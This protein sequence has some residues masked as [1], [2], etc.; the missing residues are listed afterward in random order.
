[1]QNNFQLKANGEIGRATNKTAV[2]NRLEILKVLSSNVLL[3]VESLREDRA[4]QTTISLAA[5]VARFE[6]DLIRGA[7]IRTGGRQHLAAQLLGV[8]NNTLNG[9]I[10]RYRIAL[11]GLASFA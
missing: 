4:A 10:R 3:E 8:K 9:K 2:I 6:A 5:E 1:M 11:N 7:L